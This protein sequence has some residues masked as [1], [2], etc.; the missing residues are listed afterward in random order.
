MKDAGSLTFDSNG[1]LPKA[2]A[3]MTK[4]GYTISNESGTTAPA[5]SEAA[6][7]TSPSDTPS[8]FC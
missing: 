4:G 6:T 5:A 8:E 2:S 7:N 3:D 1:S